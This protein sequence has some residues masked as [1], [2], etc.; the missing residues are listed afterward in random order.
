M[1]KKT[2]GTDGGSATV[3]FDTVEVH[4]QPPV[5]RP[6][7]KLPQDAGLNTQAPIRFQTPRLGYRRR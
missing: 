4:F 5:R 1:Q 6:E 2:D 7:E 3:D